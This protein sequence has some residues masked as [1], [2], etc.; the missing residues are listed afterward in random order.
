MLGAATGVLGSIEAMEAVK[1]LLDI[2]DPL[3]G[4]VLFLRGLEMRFSIARLDKDPA[5]ALCGGEPSIRTLA[6][7]ADDYRFD[8]CAPAGADAGE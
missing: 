6:D 1:Y 8:R 5:C 2:G 7:R 4:R 3:C